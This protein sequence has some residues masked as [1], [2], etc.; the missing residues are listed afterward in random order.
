MWKF[1]NRINENKSVL[2]QIEHEYEEMPDI[3]Y[4]KTI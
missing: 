3:I 2:F 4:D 1:E